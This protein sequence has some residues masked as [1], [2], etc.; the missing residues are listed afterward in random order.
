MDPNKRLRGKDYV[1]CLIQIFTVIIGIIT[2]IQGIVWLIGV[3][4]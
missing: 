3:I 4:K 1:G 2:V